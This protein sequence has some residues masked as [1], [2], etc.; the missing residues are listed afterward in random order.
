MELTMRGKVEQFHAESNRKVAADVQALGNAFLQANTQ[1]GLIPRLRKEG[2]L[3][4]PEQ[5]AAMKRLTQRR[6]PQDDDDDD[7]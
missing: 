4:D 1:N 3:L 5:K 2:T 7:W 6:R